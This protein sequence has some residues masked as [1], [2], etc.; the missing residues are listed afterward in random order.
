M[1]KQG[2][3][4]N[5]MIVCFLVMLFLPP[6]AWGCLKALSASYPEIMERLD[7]DTGENRARAAFP[8]TFTGNDYTYE[9]EAYVRDHAPFRSVLISCAQSVEGVTEGFYRHTLQPALIQVFYGKGDADAVLSVPQ[10]N[11]AD[12]G[13]DASV[14][15]ETV[16]DAGTDASVDAETDADAERPVT[17]E[18]PCARGIHEEIVAERVEASFLS[19]GRTE[20]VC[21][22]CGAVRFGDFAPKPV[23]TSYFPLSI[24]GGQTVLGRFG[25]LFYRGDLSLSYYQGESIPGEA[26]LQALLRQ[27]QEL[28]DVCNEKGIT[29]LFMIMPNKEQVYP[30]YMPTMNVAE[31]K[32]RVETYVDY[33]RTHSDINIIYPLRE[34]SD[35][36]IYYDTYYAYDTHWNNAGSYIGEQAV[37]AA[38]GKETTPI[39]A[40]P[41]TKTNITA[42]GLIAT[43]GLREEDYPPGTDVDL[44][45]KPEVSLISS[46]GQKSGIFGYTPKYTAVTTAEDK[47]RFV[48]LGDSFRAW[49][50]PYLEKD[51]GELCLVQREDMAL[52]KS[53]IQAADILVLS[54][55]ERFDNDLFARI[56]VITEYLRE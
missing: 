37:L 54:A 39:G 20:Y 36:K 34:L 49:M 8:E 18:D 30:E 23:D 2:R 25:W 15:E 13:T 56:P 52:A 50:I 48:L 14:E 55:V 7:Y 44:V 27:M 5:I 32:K 29:L 12:A 4:I 10:S 43:G 53:E 21:T 45:Y 28:Q 40:L 33:I 16:A 3:R 1:M 41:H 46:E 11:D 22:R 47:R 24:A 51:F 31:G 38:L 35:A 19:Y 42:R 9:V 17:E 6:L 26:E